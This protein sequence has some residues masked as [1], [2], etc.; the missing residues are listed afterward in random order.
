ML[1][2]KGVERLFSK[3][4]FNSKIIININQNEILDNAKRPHIFFNNIVTT[5]FIF[6]VDFVFTMMQ[7]QF[8]PRFMINEILQDLDPPKTISY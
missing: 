7:N 8:I 2:N 6:L 3:L 4:Y 1:K 5:S